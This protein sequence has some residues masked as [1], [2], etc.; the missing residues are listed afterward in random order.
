MLYAGSLLC[1]FANS[2][3]ELKTYCHI[4]LV[5]PVTLLILLHSIICYKYSCTDHNETFLGE[6]ILQF[7]H[8]VSRAFLAITAF[9]IIYIQSF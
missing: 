4:G 2:A 7:I 6:E 5:I 1:Y 8:K 3:S 9:I